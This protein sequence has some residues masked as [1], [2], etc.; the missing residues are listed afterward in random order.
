MLLA[1]LRRLLTAL[2]VVGTL[3]AVLLSCTRGLA[4]PRVLGPPDLVAPI[5]RLTAARLSGLARDDA[6]CRATLQLAGLAHRPL[7][8][9][10]AGACGYTN[11]VRLTPAR[12]A[13]Q[14]QPG[15][16]GVS[17]PVAAALHLWERDIVQPAARRH[18]GQDI[19]SI[20]H[21]GSYSCR[22]TYGRSDTAFSEHARANAIDVAGFTLRSGRTVSVAR[23]WQGP[24]AEAQFLRD[25]RDGACR[26][27]GT[28]LS[29]DYNAAHADHFHLDMAARGFG[30]YCR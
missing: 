26:L 18:F 23:N 12:A 6:Q 21:F 4:P 5:D 16:V 14:W 24:P 3:G 15:G 22:R 25:V 9:L 20:S 27:F 10:S 13:I 11:A 17:C 30:S 8:P 29:P 19:R 2:L 7:P 1:S 28:T